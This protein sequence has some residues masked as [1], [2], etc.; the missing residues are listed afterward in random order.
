MVDEAHYLES[1]SEEVVAEGV[2]V[3][4]SVRVRDRVA[5]GKEAYHA[6]VC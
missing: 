5:R 4:V 6:F 1:S 3:E 2:S